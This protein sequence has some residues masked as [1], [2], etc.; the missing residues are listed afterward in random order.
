MNWNRAFRYTGFIGSTVCGVCLAKTCAKSYNIVGTV[1]AEAAE[2]DSQS[3]GGTED[4]DRLAGLKLRQVHVYFRHGARTPLH[5]IPGV[6]EATY[7]R[8]MLRIPSHFDF[9]HQAQFLPDMKPRGDYSD[10]EEHYKKTTLKGGAYAGNL[11][12]YGQQQTYD[13]GQQLRQAYVHTHRLMTNYHPEDVFVQSTNI[14]RTIESLC[15]VMAGLFGRDNLNRCGVVK[16]PVSTTDDEVLFPNPHKCSVLRKVNHA[17]MVHFDNI[18]GV[19]E[20]RKLVEKA[21][22]YK[23]EKGLSFVFMRDDLIARITAGYRIPEKLQPY[24][25]M[26]DDNATKL[27]YFAMCGQ[28]DAERPIVTRLAAGPALNLMM[29]GM[30]KVERGEK[31]PKMSLYSTH[32][33]TMIALLEATGLFD[34]QWPPFAADLRM[35]LYQDKGEQLWVRVLYLGQ[36]RTIRGCSGPVCRLSE[37]QE[38]MK[39]YIIARGPEYDEICASDIVEKIAASLVQHE[40]DEVETPEMKEISE[41]PA[42]M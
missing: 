8:D 30:E 37:F 20:D 32:D 10:F 28:H 26:I 35:E 42:G 25:Q 24:M 2:S 18:P 33:S 22:G 21:L 5:V 9:K 36:P 34:W 12:T 38:S 17:A 40:Q 16:I 15:C 6:E 29:Q 14:N 1:S 11:T 19:T 7:T 41:I 3:Q 39:P 23:G 27:L 4:Q 13:L 31:A